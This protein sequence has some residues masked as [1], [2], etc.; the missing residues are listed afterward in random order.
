VKKDLEPLGALGDLGWYNIRLSLWAFD[1]AWPVAVEA[2]SYSYCHAQL[3]FSKN[4]ANR[5]HKTTED[6]VPIDFSTAIYFNEEQTKKAYF[7]CSFSLAFQQWAVVS[8]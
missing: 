8:G 6:G 2:R 1:Y 4:N 7:H 3:S 5:Y